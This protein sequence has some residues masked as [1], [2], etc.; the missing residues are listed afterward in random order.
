M[1]KRKRCADC[2]FFEAAAGAGLCRRYAPR[3][4]TVVPNG[5]EVGQAVVYFPEVD[6]MDFCGEWRAGG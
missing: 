4:L 2:E 3:P 6:P 5:P 1:D